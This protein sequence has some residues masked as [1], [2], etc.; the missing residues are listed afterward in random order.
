MAIGALLI[1]AAL[2]GAIVL[3]I[4]GGGGDSGSKTSPQVS[5]LQDRF[6]KHTIVNPDKGISVR[7][8]ANWTD[9]RRNGAISLQ[10]HDGCLAMT[11]SAP[12]PTGQSASLRSDSLHLLRR[13]Y[14][15]ATVGSAPSSQVGGIPTVS[16]TVSFTDPR[17]NP[18]KILVS[19]G[20]G[21][22]NTYLTEIVVRNPSCQAD[23][24]L[25]QLMLSSLQY[26]K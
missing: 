14:K 7:R 13:S 19:V 21:S 11:L 3:L 26:T 17:G 23:L 5:E 6:L 4:V 16:N 18:I 10:S 1:G 20:T 9:S 25:A 15:N 24:S 2:I 8:P 12:L 22:K